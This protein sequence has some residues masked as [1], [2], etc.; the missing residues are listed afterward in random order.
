M[1]ASPIRRRALALALLLPTLAA[2]APPPAGAETRRVA[3]EA[4]AQI[5]LSFAPVVKAAAPAV[6]NI[7]A[8]RVV[9]RRPSPFAG[10]PFFQRFFGQAMPQ[11]RRVENALGSGVIVRSD[12]LVV[13]NH[14][15]V[16][17]ADQIRAVLS[18]RREFDAEVVLSDPESDLVVLRLKGA[19]DLPALA[20]RDPESEGVEVGDLVLAIG[21]PFG[22][23]QTVTSGI[24]SALARSR[25]APGGGAGYYLQ[26]DAAINP[27]NSGGAL[28]DMQGRLL[29][30]NTAILSRSGGSIG[31]GFAVPAAL[32][33][34]VVAQAEAGRTTLARPWAGL[35]GQPVDGALAEALGMESPEGLVISKLHPLSP[36]AAA[37]L[38]RGDVI[39]AIDGRPVEAQ[40]ELEF[41]LAA[42]GLGKA[43]QVD[44]LSGGKPGRASLTLVPAPETPARDPQR[45]GGDTPMAGLTVANINPALGHELGLPLG[46]EG[47]AVIDAAPPSTRAGFRK[48]DV[49]RAINGRE[50]DSAAELARIARRGPEAFDIRIERDG[51]VGALRFR[52]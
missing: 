51:R 20:L 12:G 21:N 2:A 32:V 8:Q 44:F 22:V 1:T 26:T 14:H 3:P 25:A 38:A 34:Q 47:V 49:I 35:T 18:D 36:F 6:V 16:G 5:Q 9:T 43:A 27:G 31:I 17:D 29:G 15:V 41:R 7:Y 24:V 40:A 46:T 23:G 52:R 4:M 13:T 45:I 11:G 39:L 50:V 48:G 28:V 42:L 37:G 30:I 10:N 19:H 33:R